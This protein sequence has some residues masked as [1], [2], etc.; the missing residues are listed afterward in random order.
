MDSRWRGKTRNAVSPAPHAGSAAPEFSRQGEAD[1]ARRAP[2][3]GR[4]DLPKRTN[5]AGGFTM[6]PRSVDGQPLSARLGTCCRRPG[7]TVSPTVD[8]PVHQPPCV[9]WPCQAQITDLNLNP[10][11]ASASLPPYR[12]PRSSSFDPRDL[13][14]GCVRQARHRPLAVSHLSSRPPSAALILHNAHRVGARA[15]HLLWWIFEYFWEGG[16]HDDE[17]AGE[18]LVAGQIR[19][20]LPGKRQIRRGWGFGKAKQIGD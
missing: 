13:V 14:R 16:I 17:E 12:R 8:R 19:R 9:L 20:C 7:R 11:H 15:M 6:M 2:G 1:L 4:C 10:Q 5:Q 3:D 18:L